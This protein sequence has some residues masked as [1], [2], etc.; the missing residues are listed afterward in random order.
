MD[1]DYVQI[2]I[3]KISLKTLNK[4]VM[5]YFIFNFFDINPIVLLLRYFIFLLVKHPSMFPYYT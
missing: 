4:H 5:F 2:I 3:P 1:C